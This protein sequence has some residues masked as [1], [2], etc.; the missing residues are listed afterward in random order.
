MID[1]RSTFGWRKPSEP[2]YKFGLIKSKFDDHE[3]VC[4][5]N[6]DKINLP[7]KFSL[8]DIYEIHVFDQGNLNSC[9]A[10]AISN[11]I[12]LSVNNNIIP[13]RL[14]IYF[15]SMLIDKEEKKSFYIADQGASLKNAYDALF[16]FKFCDE[17]DYPYIEKNVCKFPSANIYHLAANTKNVI[18]SYR[19]IFPQLY[20]LKYILF[21]LHKPICFGMSIFESFDNIDENNYIITK[22]KEGELMLG[23]HACLIISYDDNNQTFE[24]LNSFG[25]KFGNKG[26]FNLSYDYVLDQNLSFEFYI[27]NS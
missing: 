5:F 4:M 11:Q 3:K 16:R 24:I 12:L 6:Y 1:E 14:F 23:L 18:H 9:S 13:S 15:N 8:S 7:I 26:K 17:N 27:L 20:S 21:K 19:R 2:K 10:N 22:P 25:T